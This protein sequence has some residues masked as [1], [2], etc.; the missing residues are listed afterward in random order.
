MDCEQPQRVV[1]IGANGKTGFH[2]VRMLHQHPNYSTL[3]MIRAADQATRFEEL[4]VDWTTGDLEAGSP[5]VEALEG[6]DA[7]IFAAGAGRDRPNIKKV[8]I[9]YLGAIKAIASAQET[10]SVKRF[11][12]LSG[13][14]TDPLGTR[15]SVNSSDLDGPLAAWHR[16]KAHS[17]TYLRESHVHGRALDWTILCPGRLVDEG[18]VGTGLVKASLIHGEEDLKETLSEEER[19]AAVKVMPGSHDG[20]SER[21]CVSRYNTAAALMALLGAPNTIEKSVTLVDGILPVEEALS[22]V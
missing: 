10:K 9:D 6:A 14:N 7:V 21:L 2:L 8:S 17:E 15:R 16:L 22:I 13:I 1:V 11:L 3:A 19:A 5:S 18:E 4:G 12:L 20:K